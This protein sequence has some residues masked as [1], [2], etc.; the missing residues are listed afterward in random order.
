MFSLGFIIVFLIAAAWPLA[1]RFNIEVP[2]SQTIEGGLEAP[3]V[4]PPSEEVLA[5]LENS[6][7]FDAVV[8]YTDTNG[9]EPPE[10]TISGGETIRFANN[11]S[12]RLWV[13]PNSAGRVAH[14]P[15]QSACSR[16]AFD[17][18]VELYPGDFWEFTFVK[19]GTWEFE[20]K[21]NKDKTGVIV[22][23]P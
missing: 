20:N 22:V 21:L 8:S 14:Y 5:Q 9:F 16:S 1:M 15:N 18:C 4:G 7:G 19:S 13:A 23:A 3:P 2:L 12:T 17:S 10:I 6:Q 11:S